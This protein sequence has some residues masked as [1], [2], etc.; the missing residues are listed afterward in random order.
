M[1]MPWQYENRKADYLKEIWKVIN[2]A[3]AEERFTSHQ[4]LASASL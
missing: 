2:W 3:T 1:L 4:S